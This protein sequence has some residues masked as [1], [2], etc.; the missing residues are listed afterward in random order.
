M[1]L[2]IRTTTTTITTRT[3]M[4][5]PTMS[6]VRLMVVA[7][8]GAL[9]DIGGPG[10]KGEPRPRGGATPGRAAGRS[11]KA[12]GGPGDCGAGGCDQPLPSPPPGAAGSGASRSL[13]GSSFWLIL[14]TPMLV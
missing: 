5:A 3:A 7:L 9:T 1:K 6:A 8:M 2:E 12:P 10:C 13:E 14:A 4:T 11:T